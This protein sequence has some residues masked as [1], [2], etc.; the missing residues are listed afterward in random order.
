MAWCYFGSAELITWIHFFI[1]NAQP[2]DAF[3]SYQGKEKMAVVEIREI[4]V[5]PSM[6]PYETHIR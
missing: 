3:C 4:R 6:I 2:L 1:I 5:S